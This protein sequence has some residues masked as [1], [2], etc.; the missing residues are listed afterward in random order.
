MTRLV[1]SSLSAMTRFLSVMTRSCCDSLNMHGDFSLPKAREGLRRGRFSKWRA[2]ICAFIYSLR[3]LMQ[4]L[5]VVAGGS[6]GG[7]E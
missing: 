7:C 3:T 6:G 2:E 5:W 1:D 4:R